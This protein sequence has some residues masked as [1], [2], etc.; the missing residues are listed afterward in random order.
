M[1]YSSVGFNTKYSTTRAEIEK[2]ALSG[3]F[4][5]KSLRE[6][7]HFF[8]ATGAAG[9]VMTMTAS[10]VGFT[11]VTV[12]AAGSTTTASTTEAAAGSTAA[13][14]S[15]AASVAVSAFSSTVSSPLLLT[16]H[17]RTQQDK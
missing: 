12:T 7:N 10:S 14:T 15:A 2:A 11:S 5:W 9:A 4:F 1:L 16:S 8:S 17:G 6:G 3:L 13:A